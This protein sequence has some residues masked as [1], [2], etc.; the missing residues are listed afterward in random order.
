MERVKRIRKGMN[1]IN[2]KGLMRTNNGGNANEKE[3]KERLFGEI[4]QAASWE[5]ASEGILP[6]REPLGMNS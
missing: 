6:N 3:R 2:K 5:A 4:G 1:S